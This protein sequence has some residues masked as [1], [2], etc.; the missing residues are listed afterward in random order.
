MSGSA[1]YYCMSWEESNAHFF[2]SL[3]EKHAMRGLRG[4]QMWEWHGGGRG[5]DDYIF[6]DVT[7][8]NLS[9]K[10]R[11]KRINKLNFWTTL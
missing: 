3:A 5:N 6:C 7:L 9:K 4:E 10:E 1:M 11:M 8:L 2:V